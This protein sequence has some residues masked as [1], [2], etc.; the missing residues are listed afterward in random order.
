MV[1]FVG[2]GMDVGS[3]KLTGIT[4]SRHLIHLPSSFVAQGVCPFV[5]VVRPDEIF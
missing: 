2:P 5:F 3:E 1:R 4:D